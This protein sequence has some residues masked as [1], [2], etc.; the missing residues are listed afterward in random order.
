MSLNTV[1]NYNIKVIII[2]LYKTIEIS[3]LSV[4]RCLGNEGVDK[5]P[6]LSFKG[7]LLFFFHPFAQCA[8]NLWVGSA[9]SNI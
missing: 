9:S 7:I 8:D 2:I 6:P 3:C 4:F 5:I 1:N